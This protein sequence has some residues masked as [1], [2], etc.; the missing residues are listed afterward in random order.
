MSARVNNIGDLSSL[1]TWTYP[2][3][4]KC[5]MA[6]EQ[7]LRDATVAA[8]EAEGSSMAAEGESTVDITEEGR[9]ATALDAAIQLRFVGFICR[10]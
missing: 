6:D 3:P 5:K 4:T 2:F 1:L 8:G 9:L 7:Q 10:S